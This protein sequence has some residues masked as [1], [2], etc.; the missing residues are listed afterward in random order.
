MTGSSTTIVG[1]GTTTVTVTQAAD[2]NNNAAIASMTLRVDKADPGIGNFSQITKT[3]GDQSFEIIEPSKN[4][5]NTSNFI[6]SSSN[7]LIASET[8]KIIA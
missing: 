8:V 5:N 3:F 4:S 1:A 7:P 6:Y 2:S